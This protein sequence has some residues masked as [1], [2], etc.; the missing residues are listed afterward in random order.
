MLISSKFKPNFFLKS[1]FAQTVFASWKFKNKAT[2]IFNQEA[3][4][5]VFQA[6]N[7]AKI[8]S[9]FNSVEPQKPL[10]VLMHGWEGSSNSSY[11]LRMGKFLEQEGFGIIR[12][13]FRDHGN[14][15]HLNEELFHGARYP[16][17]LE[18]IQMAVQEANPSY[19]VTVGFSLGGNFCLHL[20]LLA[21]KKI[22]SKV[23]KKLKACL[24][25]S[26]ALDP[27]QATLKMDEHPFFRWYFLKAWKASLIL[28]ENLFPFLYSFQ[29][30]MSS[31]TVMDL[32]E[33]V[34]TKY[35][36]YKSAKEYF[37]TYT[38]QTQFFRKLKLPTYILTSED[39]PVIPIQ[40]FLD[41]EPSPFLQIQIER[42][43]GH[44]GFLYGFKRKSFVND[45]VYEIIK[46]NLLTN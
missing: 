15:H 8:V 22:K 35:S 45:W 4:I 41:L 33:K 6:T 3:K 27:M 14:S 34:V 2:Q 39:D 30:L 19:F 38:I 40:E 26:P 13:N 46:D 21:S 11:M 9:F 43:G 10:V 37:N 1:P 23:F 31:K 44:C 24:S 16:E 20:S 32:T 29:G 42:F 5:R 36:N 12:I 17:I 18:V 28:K 7:G 25:I